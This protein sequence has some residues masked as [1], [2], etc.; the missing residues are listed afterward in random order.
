MKKVEKKIRPFG[1]DLVRKAPV[2]SPSTGSTKLR[3]GTPPNTS[4]DK[5]S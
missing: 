3:T 5:D 4:T 2:C 1:A